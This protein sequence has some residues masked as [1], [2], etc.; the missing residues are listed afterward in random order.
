MPQ[1]RLEFFM[2][3]ARHHNHFL[4]HLLLVEK[5]LEH[6]LQLDAEFFNSRCSLSLRPFCWA[7]CQA[8]YFSSTFW[9]SVRTFLMSLRKSA[10]ALRDWRSFC[11]RSRGQSVPS[12]GS[13]KS[14]SAMAMCSLAVK[15]RL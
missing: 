15:P 10:G 9:S 7:F 13:D 4:D 12:G 2:D 11:P 6:F 14:F 5:F 1:A 8:K 3:V